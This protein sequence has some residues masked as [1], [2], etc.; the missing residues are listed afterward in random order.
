MKKEEN[1]KMEW[2]VIRHAWI[3][4]IGDDNFKHFFELLTA[5]LKGY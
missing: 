5:V 3:Y 2:Y 1:E 4:F